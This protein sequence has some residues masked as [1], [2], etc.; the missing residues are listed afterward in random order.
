MK[1]LIQALEIFDKYAD[2][3]VIQCE[4]DVLIVNVTDDM[5]SDDIDRLKQLGFFYQE[6]ECNW[7]SYEWGSC[8]FIY[9]FSA[10]DK[11]NNKLKD[12]GH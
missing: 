10:V 3:H 4:H 6:E 8:G 11:Y 7:Y 1:E 9:T 12:E 5:D 2:G